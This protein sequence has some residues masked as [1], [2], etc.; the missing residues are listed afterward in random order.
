MT[1]YT[2]RRLTTTFKFH[3]SGDGLWYRGRIN[4][5]VD[6]QLVE[7]FYVDFGNYET[8]PLSKL[9][10]IDA[11]LLQLPAQ[12]IQCSLPAITPV[13]DVTWPDAAVEMFNNLTMH[14]KLLGKVIKKG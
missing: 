8:V 9:K 1:K 2:G 5:V 10:T 14:K 11:D 7:V 12:A 13:S 3:P 4:K 6:Q